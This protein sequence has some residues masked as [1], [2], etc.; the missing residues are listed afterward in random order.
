[1][2]SL[3]AS[4]IWWL[5]HASRDSDKFREVY[6][7]YSICTFLDNF[8]LYEDAVGV[9]TLLLNMYVDFFLSFLWPT[10]T[11]ENT[12]TFIKN[13]IVFQLNSHDLQKIAILLINMIHYVYHC[14]KPLLLLFC[15]NCIWAWFSFWNPAWPKIVVIII[16][17]IFYLHDIIIALW[18]RLGLV[19]NSW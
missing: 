16:I 14:P 13:S 5:W 4:K 3:I 18:R 1:M 8:I 11:T 9:D 15:F 7:S 6:V 2:V 10:S 19:V 12:T 17:Q